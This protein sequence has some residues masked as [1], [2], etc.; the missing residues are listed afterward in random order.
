MRLYYVIRD[1]SAVKQ[2]PSQR[3]D[4]AERWQTQPFATTLGTR[5]TGPNEQLTAH[6]ISPSGEYVLGGI[7]LLDEAVL[8]TLDRESAKIDARFKQTQRQLELVLLRELRAALPPED[9]AR[10]SHFSVE[11][12]AFGERDVAIAGVQNYLRANADLWYTNR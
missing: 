10:A 2:T 8:Q 9:S 12:V 1:Q 11:V 6:K 3:R 4:Q 7:D 5:I